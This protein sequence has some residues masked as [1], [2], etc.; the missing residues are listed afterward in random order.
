MRTLD[1]AVLSDNEIRAAHRAGELV[2]TPFD[3]D[4]VRP[5]A[6]SVRLGRGA[7]VLVPRGDGD[8]DVT[9]ASTHPRLDPRSPDESDRIRL[10]PGEVILAPTF[11]RLALSRRLAGLIDG[12][13]DYARLGISVVLCH[14]VSPGFGSEVD[15]GAVLTLE[16][17]SRLP[18]TVYLRAGMRIGNLLLLRCGRAERAY[19]D[20]PANYSR[21]QHVRPSRLA[22]HH[23][24]AC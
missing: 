13:S 4:L 21:D 7:C 23:V 3:P 18:R 24:H 1:A 14:Q 12:T 20:M 10:E 9:D 15:G 16:I 17:V 6:L 22:E 8:I 2:V 19:S 11:E 5:A